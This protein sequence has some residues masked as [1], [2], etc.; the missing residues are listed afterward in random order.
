MVS[1]AQKTVKDL[2]QMGTADAEAIIDAIEE[3]VQDTS[4]G[5]ATTADSRLTDPV[6]SKSGQPLMQGEGHA[7]KSWSAMSSKFVGHW[8]DWQCC[9]AVYVQIGKQNAAQL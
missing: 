6:L 7:H 8:H 4:H 5:S 3:L 1:G 2:E 9:H